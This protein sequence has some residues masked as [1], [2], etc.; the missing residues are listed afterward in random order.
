MART[1][2]EMKI[3]SKAAYVLFDTGALRSYIRKEFASQLRWRTIPFKVG[4]GGY[5]FEIEDSC[6]I[7][8][9]IEGLEFDIEAHPI[10]E[11]GTDEYGRR[12]DAVIGAIGMEKW[13]LVPDPRSGTIDL[14]ALRKREFIEYLTN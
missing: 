10:A 7:N 12:I 9:E 3:E 4:L 8:C 2:K 5:S 11:L 13:G 6:A 1:F 14:T